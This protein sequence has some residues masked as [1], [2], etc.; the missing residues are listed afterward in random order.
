MVDDV[1]NRTDT[2]FP[3]KQSQRIDNFHG[4]IGRKLPICYHDSLKLCIS[5]SRPDLQLMV[6]LLHPGGAV[7]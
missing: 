7:Q 4:K 3:F 1:I 6:D 5:V 2:Q